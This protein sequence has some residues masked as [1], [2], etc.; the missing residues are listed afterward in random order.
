M[1]FLVGGS[2]TYL[3]ENSCVKIVLPKSGKRKLQ[4]KITRHFLNE[5]Q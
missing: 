3:K 2:T 4:L 5:F 1:S